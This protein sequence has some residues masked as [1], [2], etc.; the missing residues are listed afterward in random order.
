MSTYGSTTKRPGD[1][2]GGE[3]RKCGAC[4][5]TFVAR[6][7]EQED[8]GILG[9]RKRFRCPHCGVTMNYYDRPDRA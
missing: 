6:P 8:L 3:S 7:I 2:A 9:T 5:R 4:G 1:E